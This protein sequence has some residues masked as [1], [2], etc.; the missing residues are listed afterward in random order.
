MNN[1]ELTKIAKEIRIDVMKMLIEAESGHPG[2][3]LS[4]VE[5]MVTLIF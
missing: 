4:E 3:S 5:L 2:G 1:T